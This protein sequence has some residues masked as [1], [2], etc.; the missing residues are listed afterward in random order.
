MTL[1]LL[2]TDEIAARLEALHGWSFRDDSLYREF[3]FPDFAHAFGFISA[4]AVI[5]ESLGHHPNWSNVYN[6]VTV[7]LTTHDVGGVTE[8][9]FDLAQRISVLDI[10]GG[11]YG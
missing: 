1:R 10:K 7:R 9:D 2:Q 11:V 4:V 3:A 8:L 5:A 6:R